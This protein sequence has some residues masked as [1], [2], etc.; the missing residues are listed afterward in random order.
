M[1]ESAF[2]TPLHLT[3]Q[4][5]PGADVSFDS[6]SVWALSLDSPFGTEVTRS[7]RAEGTARLSVHLWQ[8]A[9]GT[10]DAMLE[11]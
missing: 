11:H 6:S 8:L 7:F 1:A 9:E 10:G 3:Q 2:T 5:Q 4:T